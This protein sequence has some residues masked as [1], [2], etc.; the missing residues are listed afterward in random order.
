MLI[1]GVVGVTERGIAV[2]SSRAAAV[3][4]VAEKLSVVK[5]TAFRP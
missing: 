4:A 2:P 3:K 5:D 1:R